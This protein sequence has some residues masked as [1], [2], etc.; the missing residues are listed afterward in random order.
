MHDELTQA[1]KLQNHSVFLSQ[2]FLYNCVLCIWH[3]QILICCVTIAYPVSLCSVH[4]NLFLMFFFEGR[5]MLYMQIL[6]LLLQCTVHY[7]PPMGNFRTLLW[8]SLL[9]KEFRKFDQEKSKVIFWGR[10][11]LSAK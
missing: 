2:I 10:I 8:C 7:M 11:K 4:T 5:A 1:E 9:T 3:P 6:S